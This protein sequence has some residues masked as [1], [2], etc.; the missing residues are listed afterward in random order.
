MVALP[1][2]FPSGVRRNPALSTPAGAADG[3]DEKSPHA[4]QPFGEQPFAQLH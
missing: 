3:S 4:V 1:K 2:L